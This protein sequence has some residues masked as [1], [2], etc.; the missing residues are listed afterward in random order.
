[1]M[2]KTVRLTDK[3]VDA[4]E[5]M[6]QLWYGTDTPEF[7]TQSHGKFREKDFEKLLTKIGAW[8]QR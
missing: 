7:Q 8:D 3:E 5:S 4:I 6:S 1:M 2:A